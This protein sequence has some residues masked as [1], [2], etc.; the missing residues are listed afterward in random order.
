MPPKEE[1][2]KRRYREPT[3]RRAGPTNWVGMQSTAYPVPADGLKNRK[4]RTSNATM[5]SH[6]YQDM[7]SRESFEG[8]P[9]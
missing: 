8:A 5:C 4:L 3:G 7:P 1:R 2:K 6:S 9:F